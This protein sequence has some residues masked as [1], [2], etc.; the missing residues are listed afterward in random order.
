VPL[1]RP[2][3]RAQVPLE[4]LGTGEPAEIL[5]EAQEPVIYTITGSLG[6]TMLAYVADESP[7]GQWIILAPTSSGVVK[8]LNEGIL[9]VLEAITGSW[10][11]LAKK[12]G[13]RFSEAWVIEPSDIPSEHLPTPGT[14]LLARHQP[15]LS[16]RA[17]GSRIGQGVTP[18]SVVAHVSDATR[19]AIKIVVDHVLARESDG[20]PPRMVRALY[21]LPVRR[22]AFNSFEVDFGAPED[23][24]AAEISRKSVELLRTGLSWA[25]SD[26]DF[27]VT[28]DREARE[29]TLEAAFIL[30]PPSDGAIEEVEIRGRW[31]GKVATLN[32]QARKRI[33]REQRRQPEQIIA[34]TGRIGEL[35]RD[36]L[37]FTLRD[38]EGGEDRRGQLNEDLLDDFLE[39]FSSSQR[40]KIV[41][42]EREGRIWVTDIGPGEESR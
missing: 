26:V 7:S 33:R 42:R 31:I 10:M 13:N 17:V 5:F 18:A 36:R 30:S 1:E 19:K 3:D 16:T 27:P 4:W 35:D 40:V 32:R 41:G 6:Q 14:P 23:D 28:L 39:Y 24:E 11:W 22:I 37:A 21:D 12:V 20:R 29:A 9:T 25:Q 15:V 8:K 34:A 38:T 2:Q